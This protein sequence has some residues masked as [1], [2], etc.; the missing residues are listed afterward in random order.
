AVTGLGTRLKAERIRLMEIAE[1]SKPL[2][3]RQLSGEAVIDRENLT[4]RVE[5]GVSF[6]EFSRRLKK[7]GLYLDLPR[8]TGS[9]GGLIASKVCPDI[10]RCL[11]GLEVALADGSL[12]ELGGKTV[13]NVAGYDAVSL[14]CGSLGAYG[15]II[16]ATFALRSL[17]CAASLHPARQTPGRKRF[18]E[19]PDWDVFEIDAIHRRLKREFDPRN[20]LNPWVYKSKG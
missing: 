1:G 4:A 9:I 18:K 17:N 8:L 3:L 14:Y 6:E 10:R 16:A 20:L 15:V 13:K 5:A 12:L 11:L 2:E 19:T 7:A